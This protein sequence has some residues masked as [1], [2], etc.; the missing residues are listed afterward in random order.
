MEMTKSVER[1]SNLLQMIPINGHRISQQWKLPVFLKLGYF[2][3]ARLF[4]ELFCFVFVFGC[5]G[6]NFG[7]WDRVPWSRIKLRPPAL[8]AQSPI[9]WTK[10]PPKIKVL[11]QVIM[12]AGTLAQRIPEVLL[13]CC[14][15]SGIPGLQHSFWKLRELSTTWKPKTDMIPISNCFQLTEKLVKKK[16]LSPVCSPTSLDP[17]MWNEGSDRK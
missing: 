3:N 12:L 5:A 7:L 6:L 4:A 8:G 13:N 17:E 2:F 15:C 11:S 1:K 14:A 9:P 10:V 16:I